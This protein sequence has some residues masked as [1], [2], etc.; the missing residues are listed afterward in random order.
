MDFERFFSSEGAKFR[1][2]RGV[3]HGGITHGGE[4]SVAVT[5][6]SFG[7]ETAEAGAGT[8]DENDLFGWHG[9]SCDGWVD[10]V[11]R[12]GEEVKGSFER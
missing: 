11:Q 10:M 12:A 4:D 2:V 8:G 7:E 3:A 5:G 1:G 6:K 9:S